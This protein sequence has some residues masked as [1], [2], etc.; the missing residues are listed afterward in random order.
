[1]ATV[2]SHHY[3]FVGTSST[4][5]ASQTI[6]SL[7]KTRFAAIAIAGDNPID[8]LS[9]IAQRIQQSQIQSSASFYAFLQRI[10]EQLSEYEV[11]CSM[12]WLD[13]SHIVLGAWNADVLLRRDGKV[14]RA[15]QSG[16]EIKMIEGEAKDFD[17]YVCMTRSASAVI[18]NDIFAAQSVDV[19]INLPKYIAKVQESGLADRS[20]AVFFAISKQ[21][22]KLGI[23][24][25]AVEKSA[26]K[27]S[28]FSQLPKK[29]IAI[30]FRVVAFISRS[31]RT[32]FRTH[33]KFRYAVLAILAVIIV[34][35]AI[36]IGLNIQQANQSKIASEFL[37]PFRQQLQS[38][39]QV[40]LTDQIVA[41]DQAKDLLVELQSQRQ[42]YTQ[43]Q[44]REEIDVFEK[45]LRDYYTSV[46]GKVEVTSLPIFYDFRLIQSDFINTSADIDGSFAVFADREKKSAILVNLDTKEQKQ[47]PLG[48]Y[49]TIRDISFDREK[50]WVLGDGIYEYQIE[51]EQSPIK[52]ISVDDHINNSSELGVF[53][54]SVYIFSATDRNIYR[55]SKE[56]AGDYGKGTTWIQDKLGIDFSLISSMTIDGAIWLSFQDG[57]ILK[58]ERGNQA[59]FAI[60]GLQTP[61]LNPAYIFTKPDYENIYLLEPGAQRVLVV[62]KDGTFIKEVASPSLA[63]ATSLIVREQTKTGYIL[64]GS[65]VYEVSFQ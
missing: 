6:I 31:F 20:A 34:V 46:S 49:P 63:S 13:G 4:Q 21:Q 58:F 57:K 24:Q 62:K 38:V 59:S 44:I 61:I 54:D 30:A 26:K 51:S 15:I 43:K 27:P 11:E 18:S 14:G 48:E 9:L 25:K 53:D 2:V 29:I 17:L 12:A 22:P 40:E 16:K 50:V 37:D 10:L 64:S 1:M 8:Q 28:L 32:Q 35:I 36:I 7:D 65:V 3:Q 19:E 5:V 33:P 42:Q 41:R 55:Y 56:E 39:R 45:T 23:G 52:K 60:S 47:L